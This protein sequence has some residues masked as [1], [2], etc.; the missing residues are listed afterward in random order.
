MATRE[1]FSQRAL[2]I[3][4][5]LF[6]DQGSHQSIGCFH[7][8]KAK[9]AINGQVRLRGGDSQT[10]T[11]VPAQGSAGSSGPDTCLDSPSSSSG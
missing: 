2:L 9:K 7:T 8:E 10:P 5:D 1:I 3:G 6:L 4:T 11:G